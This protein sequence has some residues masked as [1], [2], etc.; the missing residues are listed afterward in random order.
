MENTG[1][2][3]ISL[4]EYNDLRDFKKEVEKGKCVVVVET[5]GR[6][7]FTKIETTRYYTTSQV[8]S[9]IKKVN[10]RL[11]NKIS[12]LQEKIDDLEKENVALKEEKRKSFWEFLNYFNSK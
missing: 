8:V 9:E 6:Y 11:D 3:T 12:S 1:T 2:V 4:Q 10:T 7:C 5:F